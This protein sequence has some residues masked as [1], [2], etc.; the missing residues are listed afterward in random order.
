VSRKLGFDDDALG[1]IYLLC[2]LQSILAFILALIGTPIA[3]DSRLPVA[4]TD[5]SILCKCTKLL[6]IIEHGH[7]SSLH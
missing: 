7:P 3:S 1:E 6:A 2:G 4:V 5:G